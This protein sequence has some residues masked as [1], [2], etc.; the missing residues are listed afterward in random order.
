MATK[1]K[2][3]GKENITNAKKAHKTRIGK[4]GSHH[5]KDYP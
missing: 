2:K 5:P 4:Y 1:E 3:Y